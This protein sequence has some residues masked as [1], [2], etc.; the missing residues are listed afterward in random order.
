MFSKIYLTLAVCLITFTHPVFAG[1]VE[2]SKEYSACIENSGGVT[3]NMLDCIAAE[4]KRQ[5]AQLNKAY[6]EVMGELSPERKKQLRTA[7]RLWIKYRDANCNF[8][9][10]PDGGTYAQVSANECFLN[11]TAS[12][13]KELE[14][15]KK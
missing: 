5:D 15:F 13:A 3:V 10:D 1:E 11:E 2:L 6:K 14:S 8:Y 9:A 4:T 12:R 7:Q